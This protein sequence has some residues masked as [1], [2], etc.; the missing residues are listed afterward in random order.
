[1]NRRNLMH[2]TLFV[3]IIGI[4]ITLRLIEM[5]RADWM[6]E[7]DEAI[8]GIMGNHI[9]DGERP[10]FFYGQPY[11]GALQAYVA[12]VLFS[13]FG[14][15]REAFKV[16]TV[17]EF[18]AFAVSLYALARRTYNANAALLAVLFAAIPPVYVLI[19]TT[20]LIGP[21]LPSMTLGN[22][23]LLLA[24]DEA[25]G[26]PSWGR[27]WV[28]LLVM[29]ILGGF[30]FWLHS[31]IAIYL[32]TAA[33]LLFMSD[34][35][36]LFRPELLAGLAGF[37]IGALPVF[38][39]ALDHDYTTFHH[40]L[41]VGA[42][43]VDRQYLDLTRFY[44]RTVLSRIAGIAVPLAP[45]PI[46]VKLPL[47]IVI[48]GAAL[49]LLI[50]RWRGILG[51]FRLSL[52][53]GKPKDGLILFGVV[54]SVAFIASNF[55]NLAFQFQ[56]IDATGRYAIPLASVVPILLAGEIERLSRRSFALA[57]VA[58]TVVLFAALFSYVR[59]DP[60]AM[61]QSPY[62]PYLPSSNA[63]L[64]A[65]L[66]EMGVEGVWM[67]HWAGKPLIFDSQERISSADYTD[68]VVGG[69]LNRLPQH[70]HRTEDTELP[71][72]VFVED[73]GEVELE[74]WLIE[75][76]VPYDK[77]ALTHYV[78]IRPLQKVDPAAIVDYLGFRH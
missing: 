45:A 47:A 14:M 41:G 20:K 68:L 39:Y 5:A 76:N 63:E 12:A 71:A 51:W 17:P 26:S 50:R 75:H 24:I 4:G 78:V 31:Q 66:D 37:V 27:R 54:M 2:F 3:V 13:I 65:A 77:R 46:W 32:A 49:S 8:I 53:P 1:M 57:G 33:L 29:G 61:W 74:D 43:E 6:V 25:Y 16:I 62:W 69:G 42:E 22:L 36:I 55:G 52:K 67:N 48:G 30:G 18:I 40:L 44:F 7:G 28:R 56:E 38:N 70:M 21:V 58:A 23:V 72:Y 59:T 73:D 60:V 35:R 10:I 64:I 11:M 9:R 34:K 15:S 19:N